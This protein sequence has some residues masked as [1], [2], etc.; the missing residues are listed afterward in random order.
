MPFP[1]HN[2]SLKA[3]GNCSINSGRERTQIVLPSRTSDSV[4][5]LIP[6]TS[7]R[8]NVVDDVSNTQRQRYNYD[9]INKAGYA[10]PMKYGQ[11]ATSGIG[12]VLF[13]SIYTSL[14]F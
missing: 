12:S 4:L 2:N 9:S 11:P 7:S 10:E 1:R 13:T 6:C 5:K 3:I 14:Y 8:K